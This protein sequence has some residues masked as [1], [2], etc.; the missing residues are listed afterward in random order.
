M[1]AKTIFS[2]VMV[3][4]EKKKLEYLANT[5]RLIKKMKTS[6]RFSDCLRISSVRCDE[7]FFNS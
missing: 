4:L 5:P 6:E 1:N 2:V 3:G 7:I